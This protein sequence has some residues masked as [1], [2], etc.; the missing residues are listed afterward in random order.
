MKM[1][2]VLSNE[3]KFL[4]S[5]LEKRENGAIIV[6][7]KRTNVLNGETHHTAYRMPFEVRL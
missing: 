3:I 6:T 2:S 7:R 4:S 1:H 5:S